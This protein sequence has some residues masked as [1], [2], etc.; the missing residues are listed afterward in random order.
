[1]RILIADED[2]SFAS[3]LAQTLSPHDEF[4]VVGF[5]RN[6][7]EA[8]LLIKELKP[9][10]VVTD[11][12]LQPVNGGEQPDA[13]A[14]VLLTEEDGRPNPRAYGNG[15]VACARRSDA[16]SMIDLIIG[17]TRLSLLGAP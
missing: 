17:F 8:E 10:V 4:E 16:L 6:G 9:R 5:A 2:S 14:F 13:P 1:M 11:V 7:P 3:A 15:V 12:E